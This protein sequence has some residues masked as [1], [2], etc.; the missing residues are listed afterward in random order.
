MRK[1]SNFLHSIR[2]TNLQLTT[3]ESEENLSILL[4]L[5]GALLVCDYHVVLRV[6]F[7]TQAT[8]NTRE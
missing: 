8:D 4:V 6:L 5:P 2:A 3:S 7:N 1:F